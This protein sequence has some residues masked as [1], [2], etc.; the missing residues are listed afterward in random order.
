M[1]AQ[2][3]Q[4]VIKKM[5]KERSEELAVIRQEIANYM[6]MRQG[7]AVTIEAARRP[8]ETGIIRSRRKIKTRKRDDAERQRERQRDRGKDRDRGPGF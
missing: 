7:K 8:A 4:E 1:K 3:L 2:R 5:R 6:L